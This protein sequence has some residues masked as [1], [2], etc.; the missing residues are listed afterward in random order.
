MNKYLTPL[1]ILLAVTL[2]GC[3]AGPL[4]VVIPMV[5]YGSAAHSGYNFVRE[6]APRDEIVTSQSQ[7][8]AIED[9]IL[10]RFRESRILHYKDI[11]PH[12]YNGHVYLLGAFNND[13][14]F[15]EATRLAANSPGVRSVTRCLYDERKGPVFTRDDNESMRDEI[16]AQV[17]VDESI[18]SKR[19]R[20]SVIHHNAILLGFVDSP[21]DRDRIMEHA[22]S[23]PGMISVTSYLTV[24]E[25]PQLVMEQEPEG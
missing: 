3:A 15:Q 23:V 4:A 9:R 8:I 25:Q 14:Q 21:Q 7:D 6:Y 22:K 18:R 17:V 12:C 19:M 20:V 24:E 10:S 5:Q 2:S 16:L 11:R 1:L 13:K